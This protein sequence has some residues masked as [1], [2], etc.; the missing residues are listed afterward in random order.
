MFKYIF[1][2]QEGRDLLATIPL[3][4]FFLVFVG[5]VIYLLVINKKQVQDIANLPLED[6][7]IVK[8]ND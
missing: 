6:G 5:A 8:T 1:R 2:T 7:S 4:L 3:V